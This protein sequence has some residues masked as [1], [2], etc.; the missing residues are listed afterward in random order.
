MH[1]L[2]LEGAHW[3]K[4]KRLLARAH[5]KVLTE[6]LPI[7]LI[8]PTETH[9]LKLQVSDVVLVFIMTELMQFP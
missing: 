2:Y 5:P 1:G 9:R 8:T 4:Q 7:L 6:E 3:D